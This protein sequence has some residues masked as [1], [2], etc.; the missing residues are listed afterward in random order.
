L[1]IGSHFLPEAGL[2][3]DP[4]IV[5]FPL[6]L[7]WQICIIMPSFLFHWDECHKLFAKACLEPQS[8][9]G[10]LSNELHTGLGCRSVV[11]CLTG[12]WKALGWSPILHQPSKQRHKLEADLALPGS[13][14][15]WQSSSR[16]KPCKVNWTVKRSNF[17]CSVI[18]IVQNIK[19]FL[20]VWYELDCF[21]IARRWSVKENDYI[22]SFK[23][24]SLFA[25]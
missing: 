1:D 14:G 2:N 18:L 3:Y 25:W 6:S 7:R 11:G 13:A 20:S 17:N 24:V 21:T 23:T 5:Y 9:W 19:N 16:L 4:P 15:Q 12:M 8:G 22:F 10:F